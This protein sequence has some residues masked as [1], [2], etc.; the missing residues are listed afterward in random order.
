MRFSYN[1]G[2]T[3]R[4]HLIAITLAVVVLS[5]CAGD[6][7]KNVSSTYRQ[8]ASTNITISKDGVFINTYISSSGKYA[9]FINPYPMPNGKPTLY[10]V[11]LGSGKLLWAK[12]IV[13]LSKVNFAVFG[14]AAYAVINSRLV[15][16]DLYTGKQ[17]N[18][19]DEK[20]E[21]LVE[22]DEDSIYCTQNAFQRKENEDLQ[23]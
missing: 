1:R 16:I 12:D 8:V 14:D 10:C 4:K 21:S 15:K 13:I 6:G 18:V 23:V 17:S 2:G 22:H 20:V 5:G 19:T 11:D 3:L 9:V 7:D